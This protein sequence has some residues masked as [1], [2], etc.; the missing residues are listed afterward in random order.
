M[1]KALNSQDYDRS[2]I[3]ALVRDT[4]KKCS[5]LFDS[6]KFSLCRRVCNYA[7]HELAKFIVSS[8]MSDCSWEDS[9]PTY[10]TNIVASDLL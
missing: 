3:G 10:V 6:V 9:A 8:D 1:V 7:A 2:S 5:L 4:R